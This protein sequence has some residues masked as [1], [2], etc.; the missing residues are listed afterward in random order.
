[1][2]YK[3]RIYQVMNY[4]ANNLDQNLSVEEIAE[5]ANF[6]TFHFHRIFK[7]AVGETIGVFTKRLRLEMAA[8]RLISHSLNPPTITDIAFEFGF[9]SSQNFAKAFRKHFKQTPSEFRKSK[10]GN[11]KSRNGNALSIQSVYSRF[12]VENRGRI[13]ETIKNVRIKNVSQYHVAYVRK[14]GNYDTLTHD[15]AFEELMKWAIPKG[16]CETGKFFGVYWDNPEVTPKNRCRVDAC[17]SLPPFHSTG[18]TIGSQVI[19]GG[20][21]AVYRVEVIDD[22][23]KQSWDELF[24]WIVANGYECHDSPNFQQYLNDGRYHPEKVWIVD[25]YV[26]LIPFNI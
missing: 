16:L 13:N 7:A 8:N 15:N 10:I 25:L 17:I 5:V 4:I 18:D 11:K 14:L 23:F 24:S 9:S 21:Y 12:S 3:K 1:M 6:S 20:R 22:S 19:G 2:N 26:P